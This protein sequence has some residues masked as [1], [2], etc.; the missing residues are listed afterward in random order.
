MG[1]CLC[2]SVFGVG[3]GVVMFLNKE[4]PHFPRNLTVIYDSEYGRAKVRTI[5]VIDFNGDLQWVVHDMCLDNCESQ[6]IEDPFDILNTYH[7]R[8]QFHPRQECDQP[9]F[10]A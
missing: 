7:S 10:W 2:V 9:I 5:T 1:V 3:L 8:L 6:H 4:T